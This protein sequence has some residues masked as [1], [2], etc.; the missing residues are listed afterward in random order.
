MGDFSLTK[1]E[2]LRSKNDID[3]LFTSGDS[4]ITYPFRVVYKISDTTSDTKATILISIPKKRFKRAVKRN[5]LRRRTREAY[6]HNKE[7]LLSN[8]PEHR[9]LNLAFLYI[10]NELLTYSVIEKKMKELLIRLSKTI[11]SPGSETD[12][13]GIK[14]ERIR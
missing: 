10:S 3:K 4:F 9:S 11:G 14:Q 5:L 8:I 1:N 2:R 6:R 12:I 13:S 7:Y